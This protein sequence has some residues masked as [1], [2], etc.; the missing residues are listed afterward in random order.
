[1]TPLT[2]NYAPAKTQNPK[3]EAPQTKACGREVRTSKKVG[4]ES[5]G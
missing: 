1:M 2:K 4:K 3:T 5:G